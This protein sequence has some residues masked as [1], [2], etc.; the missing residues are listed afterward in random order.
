MLSVNMRS[1]H[2]TEGTRTGGCNM[3]VLRSFWFGSIS[4]FFLGA[5]HGQHTTCSL[6]PPILGSLECLPALVLPLLVA[7]WRPCL[8]NFPYLAHPAFSRR[9]TAF[10]FRDALVKLK[11]IHYLPSSLVI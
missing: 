6:F 8:L 11:Y 4:R 3:N 10:S 2:Y 5:I 9:V 7:S 1:L